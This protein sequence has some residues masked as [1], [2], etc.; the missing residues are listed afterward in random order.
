MDIEKSEVSKK[1]KTTSGTE[2]IDLDMIKEPVI[3]PTIVEEETTQT[4]VDT[5]S[6]NYE[7]GNTMPPRSVF[8]H[9]KYSY[10]AA[11]EDQFKNKQN[12]L[13]HYMYQRE[14]S[15]VQTK[16]QLSELIQKSDEK[17]TLMTVRDAATGSLNLAITDEEKA[18]EIRLDMDQLSVPNKIWF[19]KQASEVL[20]VDLTKE[21]LAH[22]AAIQKIEK[23]EAHLKQDKASN[24]AW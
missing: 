19:H 7:V 6:E 5:T 12:L 10:A 3:T 11:V 2:V 13:I 17:V 16:E 14:K 24:K 4:M 21:T 20:Y 15:M 8:Q 23:L 1:Q 9:K 18:S 22:R